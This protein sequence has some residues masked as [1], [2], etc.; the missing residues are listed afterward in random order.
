M[1]IFRGILGIIVGVA[2]AYLVGILLDYFSFYKGADYTRV[3]PF[4]TSLGGAVAAFVA[5]LIR[6]S[7]GSSRVVVERAAKV[8][9]KDDA[10]SR[11]ARQMSSGNPQSKDGGSVTV[12]GSSPSSTSSTAPAGGSSGRVNFGESRDVPGMPSFDV[13]PGPPADSSGGSRPKVQ[14]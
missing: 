12:L 13:K 7:G 6:G 2:L 3:Y 1:A 10:M 4:L 5:M 14:Q 9:A 11:L 8:Q